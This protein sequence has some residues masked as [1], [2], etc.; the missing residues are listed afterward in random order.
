MSELKVL[1]PG[2][3][4]LFGEHA[5]VYN[6]PAIS[7]GIDLYSECSIKN[8]KKNMINLKLPNYS[9]NF[10]FHNIDDLNQN[11]PKN[12]LQF[13]LGLKNFSHLYNLDINNIE[14]EL[15]SSFW[16]GSGL[17]SSA[18][19]AVSFISALANYY[20]IGINRKEINDFAFNLEKV[21]HGTPSG[22]D[23]ITSTYGN[24][25]LYQNGDFEKIIIPNDFEILITY[26][27]TPHNTKKAIEQV[28]EKKERSSELVFNIF[29]DIEKITLKAKNEF[30][31]GNLE[32]IGI[33]M[34]ENQNFLSKLGLSNDNINKIT[35]IAR[36]N[37]A[38]GSKLTGAGIGG[39]VISLGEKK[40]LNIISDL[41]KKLGYESILTNINKTGVKNV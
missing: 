20:E 30:I 19:I 3:C 1:A 34:N 2:K 17:G 5:V 15:R 13:G 16:P 4:I 22:I 10:E 36:L 25:L 21:V 33:L 31:K 28:R 7:M 39:C 18:S 12:F 27:G 29:S 23:N 41:L 32:K 24:L 26:S 14:I 40:N 37:G 11:I 38:F 9:K 35:E 8:N 6:H